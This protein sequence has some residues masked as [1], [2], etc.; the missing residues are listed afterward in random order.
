MQHNSQ[1]DARRCCKWI[2]ITNWSI[3]VLYYVT[4]NGSNTPV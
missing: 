4:T 2:R 1:T 3:N